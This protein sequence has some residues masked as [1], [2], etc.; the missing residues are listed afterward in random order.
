[1][2]YSALEDLK[3]SS[4][5][6]AINDSNKS[7]RIHARISLSNIRLSLSMG[8]NAIHVYKKKSLTSHKNSTHLVPKIS[9]RNDFLWN[10]TNT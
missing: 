4:H 1:M 2:Y 10:K 7:H 3:G 5:V 6:V 8:P 9:L